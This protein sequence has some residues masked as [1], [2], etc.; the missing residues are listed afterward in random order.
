MQADCFAKAARAACGK[1]TEFAAKLAKISN[2]KCGKFK[3]FP[4]FFG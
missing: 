3:Q 4:A 1:R 2:K